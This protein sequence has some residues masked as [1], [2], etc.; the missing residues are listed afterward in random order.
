[1]TPSIRTLVIIDT[2]SRLATRILQGRKDAVMTMTDA[3]T[4]ADI[5]AFRC[6]PGVGAFDGMTRQLTDKQQP[7]I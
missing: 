2:A 3:T 6:G 4:A 7:P 5:E 1:M